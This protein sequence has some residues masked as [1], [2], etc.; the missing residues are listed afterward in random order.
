MYTLR[1]MIE[2]LDAVV[3]VKEGNPKNL[4]HKRLGHISKKGLKI[5]IGK[6]MIPGLKSYELDLCEH[7]IY[8]RQRRVSFMRGGHQ[9]KTN[10]SLMSLGR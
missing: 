10:P 5:L 3:A 7:C 8:G 6:N 9:L 4:W 1:E 2:I